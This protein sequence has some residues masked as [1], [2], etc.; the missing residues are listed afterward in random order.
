[1]VTAANPIAHAPNGTN[2]SAGIPF[3]SHAAPLTIAMA[4]APP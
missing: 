4:T 1:M 3:R 2:V